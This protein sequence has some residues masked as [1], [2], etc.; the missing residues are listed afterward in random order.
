MGTIFLFLIQKTG[1]ILRSISSRFGIGPIHSAES[2]LLMLVYMHAFWCW[3]VVL[4]KW[5]RGFEVIDGIDIMFRGLA[6]AV[7][8]TECKPFS[9]GSVLPPVM[10]TKSDR[11][12]N[13]VPAR[14]NRIKQ[15]VCSTTRHVRCS[16]NL[17]V[18]F[19]KS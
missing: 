6:F 16:W 15:I 1:Y 9:A 3:S 2:K 13:I 5:Y 8:V 19:K 14:P 7:H 18:H 4:C 17:I 12:S 10:I 11:N